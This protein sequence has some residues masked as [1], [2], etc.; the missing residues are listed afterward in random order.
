MTTHLISRAAPEPSP[1]RIRAGDRD[2]WNSLVARE[3]PRLFNLH[4]RLCGDREAAADMTQETFRAAFESCGS[5]QG[6]CSAATW[7]YG[8]A[9]NVNRNWRRRQGQRETPDVADEGLAD[10]D[11][12]P[13]QL[14]LMQEQSER[15]Y[16]AV[17]A[18]PETYREVVALRY[19]AGVPAV[20]IARA[21][22]LPA[23]T[24]R[25]RLHRALKLLWGALQPQLGKENCHD[26]AA[27]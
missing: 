25:W 23:E 11:P 9:L 15:V 4:R 13:E 2:A 5:F 18:L 19:F 22:G 16:A 7:L 20:E 10:P 14:A 21:E 26:T 6:R 3:H 24:V 27:N 12:T 8:V 1:G 17:A